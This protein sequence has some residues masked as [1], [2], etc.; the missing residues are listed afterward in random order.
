MAYRI[1]FHHAARMEYREAIKWYSPRSQDAPNSLRR[2]INRG[3][4]EILR[5]PTRWKETVDQCREFILEVFPYSL[6]YEIIEDRIVILAL[7]H[8]KRRPGYWRGR[9]RD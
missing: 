9:V 1:E 7:A 2:E 8:H 3:R 4:E 5:S 6:I